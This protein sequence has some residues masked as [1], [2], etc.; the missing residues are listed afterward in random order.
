MFIH[1][2]GDIVVK[3]ENIITI[4][5]H[6][7]YD[8]SPENKSFILAHQK[9]DTTV[10]VTKEQAKSIVVTDECVYLS[11]ISSHTLKRRAQ[12]STVVVEEE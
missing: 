5:D 11:P 6:H 1:L 7:T 9:K 2:G 8:D 3:A 10:H 4:L 12:V